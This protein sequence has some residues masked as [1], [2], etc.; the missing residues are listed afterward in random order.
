MSFPIVNDS[1]NDKCS[2]NGLTISYPAESDESDAESCVDSDAESDKESVSSVVIISSQPAAPANPLP[3]IKEALGSQANPWTVEE[4]AEAVHSTITID[5]TDAE[6]GTS[7]PVDSPMSPLKFTAILDEAVSDSDQDSIVSCDDVASPMYSDSSSD[8]DASAD[9]DDQ[10]QEDEEEEEAAYFNDEE[11][12]EEYDVDEELDE[13]LEAEGESHIRYASQSPRYTPNSPAYTAPSQFK[14]FVHDLFGPRHDENDTQ[15]MPNKPNNPDHTFAYS[16]SPQFHG[17]N[18][19]SYLDGPFMN[20][21]KPFPQHS[22]VGISDEHS[23]DQDQEPADIWN[24]HQSWLVHPTPPLNVAQSSAPPFCFGMPMQYTEPPMPPKNSMMPHM[25][26]PVP[27]PS[28]TTSTRDMIKND[29]SIDS[30][31]HP[32]AENSTS[33]PSKKRSAEEMEED[34]AIGDLAVDETSAPVVSELGPSSKP[35]E[36]SDTTNE[37]S[38]AA[39]ASRVIAQP[40]SKKRKYNIGGVALGTVIGM[41]GTFATMMSLPDRIFQ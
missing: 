2:S 21:P 18:T 9:S 39:K 10:D 35:L 25:Q 34:E 14:P 26:Q 22:N 40:V 19:T 24:H 32:S 33:T 31:I 17:M 7:N 41:V 4:I 20:S 6:A 23:A 30:L 15:S 12:Q 13:A 29:M 27:T 38:D 8:S 1:Q 3:S 28:I 37:S 36:Q 16:P 5:L 11:Q